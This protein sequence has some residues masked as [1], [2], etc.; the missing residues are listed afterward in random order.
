MESE[1]SMPDWLSLLPLA[2]IVTFW[3][4]MFFVALTLTRRAL[5]GV[6]ELASEQASDEAELDAASRLQ[7]E[8]G[9]HS[10]P[11]ASAVNASAQGGGSA[12]AGGH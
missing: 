4:I 12:P 8:T 7:T 11:D 9:G 3:A 2:A 1:G 6:G 5:R 10:N